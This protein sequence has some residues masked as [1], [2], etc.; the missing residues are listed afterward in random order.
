[1]CWLLCVHLY[2][3]VAACMLAC[4]CDCLYVCFSVHHFVC[5]HACMHGG[6]FVCL[7]LMYASQSDFGY[8][9]LSVCVPVLSSLVPSCVVLCLFVVACPSC[10]SVRLLVCMFALFVVASECLSACLLVCL[11]FC[12]LACLSVCAACL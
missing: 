12:L 7:F 10:L 11:L 8:G 2:L 9:C 6:L 1:M 4:L 3:L 5:V